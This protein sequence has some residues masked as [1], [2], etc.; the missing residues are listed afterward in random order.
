LLASWHA[1]LLLSGIF[2]EDFSIAL[3]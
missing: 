1:W 2:I 3:K